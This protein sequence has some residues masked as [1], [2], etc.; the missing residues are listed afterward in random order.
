M[1]LTDSNGRQSTSDS[2]KNHMPLA[3][4]GGC[5]IDIVV[6]YT[7]D[8]AIQRVDRGAIDVRDTVTII[9]NLT[10]DIRGTKL[11]P[12]MTPE[13]L[14]ETVSQ[15]RDS[16]KK[17]GVRETV[18]CEVKPMMMKDVDPYNQRLSGYLRGQSQGL[19]YPTQIRLKHLKR[20]GFHVR[21]AFQGIIDQTYAGAIKMALTPI[22]GC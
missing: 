17:A 15:L 4:R 6:A 18:I 20:D 13:R 7:L 1:I 8:E 12:S 19:G 2:I 11:R 10:N 14:V 22:D 5:D 9:D 3:D 21:Y 16:L